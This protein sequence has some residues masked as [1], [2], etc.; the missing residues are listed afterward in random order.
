MTKREAVFSKDLENKKLTVVRTFDA[1]LKKVWSAWTESEKLDKW[2]AP[3]PYKAETKSMDFRAGGYWLYCMVGPQ[4]ER[5][6]CKVTFHKIEAPTNFSCTTGFSDEQGVPNTDFPAT[7]W[8]NEFQE[9]TG[10]TTVTVNI[11]FDQLAD[12]ET[13]IAMGF[14]E[15]FTAGLVNLDEYLESGH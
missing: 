12:M 1:P 2:W 8:N 9:G 10:T 15:G 13:I 7:H 5:T 14:Q 6:W 4:G 11:S 3:K